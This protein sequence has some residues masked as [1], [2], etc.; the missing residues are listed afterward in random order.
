MA[1]LLKSLPESSGAVFTELALTNV[2]S[3]YANLWC[4]VTAFERLYKFNI[5]RSST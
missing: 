4:S 2:S 5:Q 1:T 3:L